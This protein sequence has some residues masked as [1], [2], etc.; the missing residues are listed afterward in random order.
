MTH[1]AQ[2]ANLLLFSIVS[3][4]PGD[5]SAPE[6]IVIFPQLGKLTT[7]DGRGFTADGKALLAAFRED[8]IEIPVDEMHQTDTAMAAGGAARAVG[9]ISELR[10]R[11]GALEG[12]VD[13][14]DAG[15]ALLAAKAYRYTSP[16]F[17]HDA[18][19]RALR[20]KA[21]ALV[22]APA[23]GNQPALAA[24]QTQ[25]EPPMKSIANFLGLSEDANESSCLAALTTRMAEMAP[26]KALDEAVAN[27]AAAN[28][29]LDAVNAAARAAK[30][31]ALIGDALKA[32][33]IIPAEKDHYVALCATEVG[34][35]AVEKLFAA[36]GAVLAGSGLDA[37]RQPEPG[38]PVKAAQLAAKATKLVDEAR[39]GGRV[40]NYADA[41][42]MVISGDDA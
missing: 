40:L 1:K 14:A 16:S 2:A 13:W 35:D 34:L 32:K 5:G 41:M 12:K 7:R 28:A 33:K 20:L 18:E 3:A 38:A 37:Q 39:A 9:W 17:F 8:G 30:V 29:R 4:L 21:V 23:L 36:K 27:L 15:K 31:D 24:A 10:I 22:T 25:P 42:S 11:D 19:G 6:W 26:K